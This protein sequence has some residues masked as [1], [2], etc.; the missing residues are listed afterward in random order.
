MILKLSSRFNVGH[1]KYERPFYIN[2][3]NSGKKIPEELV[4]HYLI[5]HKGFTPF[6]VR[7]RRN[8]YSC[9]GIVDGILDGVWTRWYSVTELSSKKQSQKK[10][11][12]S[13]KWSIRYASDNWGTLTSYQ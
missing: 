6:N 10:P 11:E 5:K 7:V 1:P 8:T 3:C 12:D 9:W 2:V 13:I 4:A